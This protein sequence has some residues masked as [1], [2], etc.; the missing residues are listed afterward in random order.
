MAESD[1]VFR[2]KLLSFEDQEGTGFL[3]TFQ[4][5]TLWKGPLVD[6]LLVTTGASSAE[7]GYAFEVG[8]VYIVYALGQVPDLS[9]NT[10][11]R[12]TLDDAAEASALGDPIWE[13][14]R[15]E[16]FVRSDTDGQTGLNITD[17]IRTLEFL[18]SGGRELPCR[19]AADAN[20][21]GVIDLSDP[22]Y[23]LRYLFSGTAPPPAPFPACGEDPSADELGC[24]APPACA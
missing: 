7:C 1:V 2:G 18:F 13:A 3:A 11:T 17:A 20:D 24:A 22:V 12:T 23:H 5:L 19:D 21:D 14:P 9:T 6:P 8:Q 15:V 10:C 16:A 4:V